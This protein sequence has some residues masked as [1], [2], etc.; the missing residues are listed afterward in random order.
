MVIHDC[1]L[2]R[3]ETHLHF[4]DAIIEFGQLRDEL[5]KVFHRLVDSVHQFADHPI[6]VFIPIEKFA[7]GHLKLFD[8][9]IRLSRRATFTLCLSGVDN[10]SRWSNGPTS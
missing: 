1:K 2:A 9:G 5:G 8:N 10:P 7:T 3:T 4:G 6:A